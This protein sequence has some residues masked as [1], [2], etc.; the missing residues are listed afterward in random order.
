M[1]ET[2]KR[3]IS[4]CAVGCA[5]AIAIVVVLMAAGYF[6]IRKMVRQS[7]QIAATMDAVTERFGN[8]SDFTP[9]P[10]GAVASERLAV[11]LQVRDLTAPERQQ[12]EQTLT[13]LAS[14]GSSEP[15][16]LPR[17]LG[18]IRAGMG[19]V[20][21]MMRY[22]NRRNEAL[23]EAGMG[24]GEYL[25]LYT[26]VYP[27]WL[28]TPVDDGPPFIG[29][30]HVSRWEFGSEEADPERRRE[31]VREGLNRLLLPM[32]KNQLDAVLAGA[33][34]DGDASWVTQLRGEIE[35]LERDAGRL[36]WQDGLP[37]RTAESL[38]PF[39]DRLE[40]SYSRLCNPIEVAAMH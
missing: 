17:G 15:G 4:G 26:I 40:A 29:S 6:G 3:W 35:E 34:P 12:L 7:Q 32:L 16:G 36:P 20:P 38:E 1:E 13:A 21:Q 5:V 9:P 33:E 19:V 24:L 18:S 30:G 27:C 10:S 25:Y 23:L 11:F 2:S 37:A 39:R 14:A 8:V 31:Q 22:L 28:A